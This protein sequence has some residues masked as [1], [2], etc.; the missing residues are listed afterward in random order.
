MGAASTRVAEM[1]LLAYP[2]CLRAMSV[3]LGVFL[4]PEGRAFLQP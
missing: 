3:P 2:A 4:R 1:A